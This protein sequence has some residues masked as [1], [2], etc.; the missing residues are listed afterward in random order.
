MSADTFCCEKILMQNK[1]VIGLIIGGM[2]FMHY[3]LQLQGSSKLGIQVI[4]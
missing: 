2:L 3:K 4:Y 1:N